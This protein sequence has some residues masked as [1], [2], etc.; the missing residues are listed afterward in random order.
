MYG[1]RPLA[2]AVRAARAIATNQVARFM[3]SAYLDMT[4]ETGRGRGNMSADAIADYHAR[5]FDDYLAELGIDR[6][7][8]PA[9]LAGKHVLEYGPGDVPGVALLFV[10]YGAASVT[11][12]DRFALVRNDGLAADVLGRLYA[13]LSR[14]ERERAARC[15]SVP[16][17]ASAPL[18]E[19]PIRY[20]VRPSGLLG[21]EASMA[22]VV[23]RA[24][25]EHVNDLRA[26]FRDMR[27]ALAPDG[28]ALHLVDLK[29]HGLHRRNP[30]DFLTWPDW[31]W[32]MMYSCKGVPNRLRPGAYRDAAR[33]AALQITSM[34][35][36][37]RARPED[38]AEVRP[39]LAAPFRGEPD[40]ELGWSG[41]WLACRPVPA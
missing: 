36:T 26:T 20:V 23:S 13:A 8:A 34:T 33:E 39:H 16:G 22:L 10:A 12:I 5:C 15:F 32:T 4:G 38:I 40:E 25:L 35:P 9:A 31:L 6:A 19:G 1:E 27:R 18:A 7:H 14:P 24:V 30:L 11:C 17:D 21:E 37:G 29:S 28:V 2:D 3:P 41:F